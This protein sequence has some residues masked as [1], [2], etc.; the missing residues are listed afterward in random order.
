MN[1]EVFTLLNDVNIIKEFISKVQ[2]CEGDVD[3][4]SADKR[5]VVDAKSVMGIFSLDLARPVC[6]TFHKES[7]YDKLSDFII[8]NFRS[9]AI[10]K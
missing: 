6:I 4:M 7:D 2:M 1:T 3:I 5:Y 9:A 10:N 8:K